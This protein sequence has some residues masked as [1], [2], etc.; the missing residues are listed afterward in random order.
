[1]EDV[2]YI[3]LASDMLSEKH[4]KHI[5]AKDIV[6]ECENIIRTLEDHLRMKLFK[7]SKTLALKS[8]LKAAMHLRLMARFDMLKKHREISKDPKIV[9]TNGS[10]SMVINYIKQY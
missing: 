8:K 2:G 1:M 4:F 7:T 3:K 5:I 6:T 9:Y 10:I